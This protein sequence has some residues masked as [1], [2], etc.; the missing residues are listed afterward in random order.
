MQEGEKEEAMGGG[1]RQELIPPKEKT[2]KKQLWYCKRGEIKMR[3]KK[4]L[5]RNS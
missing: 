3:G 2:K 4:E 5:Q 1:R